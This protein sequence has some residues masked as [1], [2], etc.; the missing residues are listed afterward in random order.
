M[1]FGDMCREWTGSKDLETKA[2]VEEGQQAFVPTTK[3]RS[4]TQN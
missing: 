3:V 4:I 1:F 2:N